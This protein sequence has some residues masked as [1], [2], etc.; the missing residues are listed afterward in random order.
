MAADRG[1]LVAELAELVVGKPGITADDARAIGR[2]LGKDSAPYAALVQLDERPGL[3]GY[4]E[5]RGGWHW[6]LRQA[7]NR[8]YSE[9]CEGM[10]AL[11]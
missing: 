6:K 10:G 7:R 2:I 11:L 8:H 4:R 3:Y 5:D 9:L 1:E